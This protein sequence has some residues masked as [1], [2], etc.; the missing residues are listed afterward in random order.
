MAAMTVVLRSEEYVNVALDWL[1]DKVPALRSAMAVAGV[2]DSTVQREAEQLVNV[3]DTD[4]ART[5]EDAGPSLFV[6]PSVFG[7]P[8]DAG[9]ARG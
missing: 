8:G 1:T 5:D 6:G 2:K 3:G 9:C 7:G 4:G